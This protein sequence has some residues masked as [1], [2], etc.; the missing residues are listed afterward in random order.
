M[1]AELGIKPEHTAVS[2][3]AAREALLKHMLDKA[4]SM[5]QTELFEKAG[6]ITRTTGEKTLK[7]LLA[8]RQIQRIGAGGVREPYRYFLKGG[9]GLPGFDVVPWRWV[10]E[11]SGRLHAIEWDQG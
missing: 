7:A 8:G 2:L 10:P 9:G 1:L 6:I 3:N 11:E 5:T 4:H